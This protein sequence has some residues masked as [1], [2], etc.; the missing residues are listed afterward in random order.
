[1]RF[2][3]GPGIAVAMR[4]FGRIFNLGDFRGVRPTQIDP[5]RLTEDGRE[6]LARAIRNERILYMW[7]AAGSV[8]L[9]YA[10]YYFKN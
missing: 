5:A 10:V 1:M 7:L 8:L 2:S 9:I 6:H 4:V 3:F